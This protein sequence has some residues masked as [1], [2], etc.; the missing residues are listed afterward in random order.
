MLFISVAA[1]QVFK[2]NAY[3][4]MYHY[5]AL[6]NFTALV[7]WI[8][9]LAYLLTHHYEKAESDSGYAVLLAA[10]YFNV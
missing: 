3:V 8:L 6:A 9:V 5:V 10:T 2:P 1:T 7:L 4:G